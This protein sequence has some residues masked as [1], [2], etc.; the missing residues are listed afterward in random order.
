MSAPSLAYLLLGTS[1]T[2][3]Y[4]AAATTLSDCVW[5]SSD[6]AIMLPKYSMWSFQ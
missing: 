6:L 4:F 1:W 5:H 2:L 3:T